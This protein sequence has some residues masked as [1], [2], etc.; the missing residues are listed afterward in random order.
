M[1]PT[2]EELSQWR[3]AWRNIGLAAAAEL[4]ASYTPEQ[5]AILARVT[6]ANRQRRLCQERIRRPA[7]VHGERPERVGWPD[8]PPTP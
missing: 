4:M 6:E 2:P 3:D 7:G 5:R 8:P 1:P